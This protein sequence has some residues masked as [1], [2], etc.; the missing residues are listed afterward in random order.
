MQVKPTMM[1]STSQSTNKYK[2]ENVDSSGNDIN[3]LTDTSIDNGEDSVTQ[4]KK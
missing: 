1:L 4:K 2:Y 3:S